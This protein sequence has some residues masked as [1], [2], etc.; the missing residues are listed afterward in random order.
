MAWYHMFNK[1]VNSS[2]SFEIKKA[3]H[4]I[5]ET[6]PTAL[7]IKRT[8]QFYSKKYYEMCVKPVVDAEWV[9]RKDTLPK[10]SHVVYSNGITERLYE[11]ESDSFKK[12]LDVE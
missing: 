12:Q 2:N 8:T 3:F 9:L 1:K 11:S 4:E 10:L 6:I 7:K 5:T